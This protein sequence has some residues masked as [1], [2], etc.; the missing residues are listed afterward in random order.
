VSQ[1][2]PSLLLVVG[3][4]FV[5][6]VTLTPVAAR[7]AVAGGWLDRPD[8]RRKLHQAPVPAV[9]GVAVFAGFAVA[10]IHLQLLERHVFASLTS[11]R[12]L[13][14]PLVVAGFCVSL[15]GLVDD[16][17]GVRPIAKLAV[18]ATAAVYLSLSGFQISG[19]SNPLGGT[20]ALGALGLPVTVLWLVGMSNAFNLIDGLDGLAAG[21]ALVSTLGLMAAAAV[22]G[23]WETVLVAGALA[24]ALL[25]FL[26]YNMN[27]ARVFL[28]DCGAL[29]VGFILA[30]IAVKSSIKASAAIA[31]AVPL[32]ALALPILDVGLAVVRRVVRRR[33]VFEGDHDHIH[34]RLVDLGLTPRRAVM[35]LYGV[36]VL[37]TSLGLAIA[38]GPRHV[39][40]AVAAVVLLVVGAGVRALG[41]WEVT[42]FQ[43]SFVSRLVPGLRE[44]GEA[45]LRGAEHDIARMSSIDAGWERLYA[46]AWELGLTELHLT[47]RPGWVEACPERH[48]VCPAVTGPAA[49]P[50]PGPTAVAVWS[51]DVEVGEEVVAEVVARRPLIR[52]DFDPGRFATIVRGLARRQV[53]AAPRATSRH[54][55]LASL[56]AS[57]P[58]PLAAL[59]AVDGARRGVGPPVTREPGLRPG[60]AGRPVSPTWS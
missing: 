4:A 23:R 47:P 6:A 13:W 28:G 22:S 3:I 24:G 2:V 30:A 39:V 10:A 60:V 16:A 42:E 12:E 34:H 21:L 36:A 9:G 37:F 26:P 46:T 1:P 35:T 44:S 59:L 56:Q 15:I 20:F 5:V 7:L 49:L 41:Y 55:A 45:A 53:E 54:E 14:V 51:I 52:V 17:R 32:L 8:G 19:V 57:S 43:R 40:W 31:V 27:P 38:M 58:A 11:F 25:G 48:S 50:D 29:P 33:P 18:Q